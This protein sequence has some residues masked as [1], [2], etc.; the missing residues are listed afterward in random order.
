MK[1]PIGS[2]EDVVDTIRK[3]D[4]K[5]GDIAYGTRNNAIGKPKEVGEDGQQLVND[6]ALSD[7][8]QE[9]IKK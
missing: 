8:L 2:L 4:Q 1:D 5:A 6:S 3:T 7:Y 9:Q